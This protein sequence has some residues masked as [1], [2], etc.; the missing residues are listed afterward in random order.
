MYSMSG[1]F[2]HIAILYK[3][4]KAVTHHD[5]VRNQFKITWKD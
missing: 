1:F 5:A 4:L 2:K 3:C